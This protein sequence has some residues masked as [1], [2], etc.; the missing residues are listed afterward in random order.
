MRYYCTYFDA[1]YLIRGLALYRSLVQHA[2]P[3]TLWVLC[4]DDQAYRILEH[5]CLPEVKPV[6]LAEFEANDHELIQTKAGRSTIEYYFTCTPSWPL[7]ILKRYPHVDIIT[8]LDAD[9]Y[10]SANPAPLYEELGDNSILIIK[11]RFPPHLREREK[12]NGEYNV[13]LLSFRN[14]RIGNQCLARW[15]AQ[16][17]EWCFD[18]EE[19]GKYADQK[20][21]DD[22]PG[23]FGRVAV[24][25]H[26][27][28]GLSPWN[29]GNYALTVADGKVLVDGQPLIFYHYH[30]L[31][32]L[33]GWLY[34]PQL[35]R[36]GTDLTVLIKQKIYGPY[37]LE[38]RTSRQ[39]LAAQLRDGKDITSNS[40]R[41]QEHNI[42]I[43]SFKKQFKL[44][45]Q[46]RLL[47]F[48]GGRVW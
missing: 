20:Y 1:N 13:S 21:L 4:F 46:N 23:Q 28:A 25:K 5:L 48:W 3:F 34:D 2:Q 30:G 7:Y 8:Y 16:C 41:N 33:R 32:Q 14:D 31:K 42:E 10:F 6:R 22:W 43:K 37:L 19:D 17:I 47:V 40:I 18:R 24:L 9:L 12:L 35:A 26:S 39:W 36:Y 38:L 11:H 29:I 44:L 27:G 45:R 15:R